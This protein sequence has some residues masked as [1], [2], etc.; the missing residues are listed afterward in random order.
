MALYYVTFE[1][2]VCVQIEARSEEEAE[3]K[4]RESFTARDVQLGDVLDIDL[5]MGDDEEE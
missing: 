5:L 3:Q 4:G 2:E 1:A